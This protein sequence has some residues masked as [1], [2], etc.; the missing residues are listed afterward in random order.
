VLLRKGDRLLQLGAVAALAGFNFGELADQLP[1]AAV[2]I[3]AN[4]FALGLE[5]EAA[6]ALLVRRNPVIPMALRID[7]CPRAACD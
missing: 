5:A 3:V 6:L 7:C 2:E 1:V 4:G